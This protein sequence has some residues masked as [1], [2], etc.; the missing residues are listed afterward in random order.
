VNLVRLER[1]MFVARIGNI[2]EAAKQ[3]YISQSALSQMINA[4]EEEL[5]T[6]IF[7]R[8]VKPM[9]L[10][11][12]GEHYVATARYVLNAH[13]AMLNEID[14][15]KCGT[16]GVISMGVSARRSR[17]ILPEILHAMS[18]AYPFI[19]MRLFTGN[20]N[21]FEALLLRGELDMALG[22]I[23]PHD[24]TLSSFKLNEERY[25]LLA[26]R[27]SPFARRM[28]DYRL[29]MND[30]AVPISLYEARDERFIVTPQRTE[31]RNALNAMLEEANMRP[32][33]A[34]EVFNTDIAVEYSKAGLGVSVIPQCFENNQPFRYQ[35]DSLSMFNIDSKFAQRNLYLN[36]YK[37][38]T[39][40]PPHRYL[41]QLILERYGTQDAK[42]PTEAWKS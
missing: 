41:I 3:L 20:V 10:T 13:N 34:I 2:T 29:S 31:S 7:D 42:L 9:R 22:S 37:A 18:E 16:S 40:S 11:K 19:S 38:I 17:I 15:I 28:D 24:P 4:V 33:I 1:I 6:P 35:D 14:N 21:E 8:R 30:P 32:Q 5:G 27:D 25:L 26:H 12:A 36:Y 39:I 23:P